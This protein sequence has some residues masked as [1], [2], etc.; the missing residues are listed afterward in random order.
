SKGQTILFQ[1][2]IVLVTGKPYLELHWGDLIGH[3]ANALGTIP[4]SFDG[5]WHFLA[6]VWAMSEPLNTTGYS[7][8][9]DVDQVESGWSFTND[10]SHVPFNVPWNQA[11]SWFVAADQ[12]VSAMGF[13]YYGP[14]NLSN[15]LMHV[16]PYDYEIM[17][18]NRGHIGC[19]D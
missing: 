8:A 9:G 19:A 18:S 1:E 4:I 14:G 12:D 11:D 3:W 5:K 15:V 7:L 6:A 17:N 13:D 16:G 10:P 2:T